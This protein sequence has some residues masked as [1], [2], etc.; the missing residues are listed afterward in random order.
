MISSTSTEA[1][2]DIQA[3]TRLLDMESAMADRL[4]EAQ[5]QVSDISLTLAGEVIDSAT[6]RLRAQVAFMATLGLCTDPRTWLDAQLRFVAA[7]TE[8]YAAEMATLAQTI[9]T[10]P[11]AQPTQTVPRETPKRSDGRATLA[12]AAA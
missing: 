4:F 12:Q 7:T 8:D 5:R 1:P 10:T 3:V 6:R 2:S 11:A 9:Q